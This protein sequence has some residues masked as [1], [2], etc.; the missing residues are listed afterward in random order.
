VKPTVTLGTAKTPDGSTLVLRRRDI[1]YVIAVDGF[2]LMV[3]TIHRSESEMVELASPT[4]PAGAHVLIGGLGMGFTLRAALDIYPADATVVVAEL[5][6][7]VVEWNR[8]ELGGVAGRPL[9]DPR[10]SVFLGDVAD[11]IREAD[12]VY[13]AILLDVD[14]GPDAFTYKANRWLYT[15]GGLAAIRRALAPGGTLALWSAT[16]DPGFL[17]RLRA[18]GL[19]PSIKRIRAHGSKS[20]VFL[21]RK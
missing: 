21:G 6:P 20:W 5:I 11:A 2:T 8:G 15:P 16:D 17:P 7:E 19:E 14:N 3:N 18:A 10:T 1:E 12:G 4:P 13:E 9:D